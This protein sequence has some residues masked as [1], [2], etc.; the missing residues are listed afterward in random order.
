MKNIIFGTFKKPRLHLFKSNK[1]LYIQII[2]DE[3]GHSILSY[4][5]N[6]T[7]SINLK[8]SN[9]NSAYLIGFKLALD[10]IKKNII[11]VV[12]DIKNNTYSGQVKSFCEGAKAAG[13][14]F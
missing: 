1:N 13:L 4:S 7:K 8:Q 9:V 3:L 12:L 5:T 2:N 6:K 11:F 10:A 14:C